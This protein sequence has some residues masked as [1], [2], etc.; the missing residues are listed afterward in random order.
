M[1]PWS[2]RLVVSL[3]A[4]LICC[5]ACRRSGASNVGSVPDTTSAIARPHESLCSRFLLARA[6]NQPAADLLARARRG[7]K[8]ERETAYRFGPPLSREAASVT[9]IHSHRTDSLIGL[10]Y[11]GLDFG[12]YKVMEGHRELLRLVTLT[13]SA[14]VLLPGLKVGAPAR[15]LDR[16]FGRAAFRQVLGNDSVVVQVDLARAEVPD[17]LD[18]VL[19][20]DTIRVIEWRFGLD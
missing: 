7:G 11:P 9:N 6:G 2:S 20:R 15:I 13:D 8:T 19:V 12:F 18:F 4:P 10:H 1:V 3:L 17:Y 16:L 14:C 5:A